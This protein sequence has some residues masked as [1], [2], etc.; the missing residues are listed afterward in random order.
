M[1]SFPN[2][3]GGKMV[4]GDA[5]VEIGGGAIFVLGAG[6]GTYDVTILAREGKV[7]LE[8]FQADFFGGDCFWS[9]IEFRRDVEGAVAGFDAF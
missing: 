3:I 4:K 8:V 5:V 7:E 6:F 2:N 9:C 1:P